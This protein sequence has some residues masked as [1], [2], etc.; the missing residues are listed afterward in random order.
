MPP[1]D[2]TPGSPDGP[3]VDAPFDGARFVLAPEEKSVSIGER[4]GVLFGAIFIFLLGCLA[5]SAAIWAILW[6]WTNLPGS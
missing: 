5:G 2:N 6:L 4:L 3:P 1:F